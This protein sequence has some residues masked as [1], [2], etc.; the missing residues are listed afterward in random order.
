MRPVYA[1]IEEHGRRIGLRTMT[2][3]ERLRGVGLV[4][5]ALDNDLSARDLI[6]LSGS[7]ADHAAP[8]GL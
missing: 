5:E 8:N 6:S 7:I 1:W 4:P 3:E 2:V